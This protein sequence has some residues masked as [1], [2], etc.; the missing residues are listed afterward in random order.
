MAAAQ[1][2]FI[3]EPTA[4]AVAINSNQSCAETEKNILKSQ[5]YTVHQDAA[6]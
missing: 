5:I 2:Q 1:Y 6:I 4:V 3:N